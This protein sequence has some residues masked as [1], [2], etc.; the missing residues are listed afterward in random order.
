V[1]FYEIWQTC[2]SF[3]QKRALIRAYREMIHERYRA[4]H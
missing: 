3:G 1:R 2:R 4:F